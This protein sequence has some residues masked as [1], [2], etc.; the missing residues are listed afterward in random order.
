M[1]LPNLARNVLRKLC[2]THDKK[3]KTGPRSADRS[4]LCKIQLALERKDPGVDT[5]LYELRASGEAVDDFGSGG[6]L[7]YTFILQ[8]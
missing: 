4:L 5:F 6:A 8:M 2:A 7:Y 1:S 3:K